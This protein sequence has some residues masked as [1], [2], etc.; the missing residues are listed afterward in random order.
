MDACQVNVHQNSENNFQ[1]HCNS[2][3]SRIISKVKIHPFL[4]YVLLQG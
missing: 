3:N 1:S 4:Q 2:P